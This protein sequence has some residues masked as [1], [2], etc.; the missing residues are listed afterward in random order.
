MAE[1]DKPMDNIREANYIKLDGR[2]FSITPIAN[3]EL[4][5]EA[6]LKQFYNEK[7]QS[8]IQIF[9]GG[10][11]SGM[12]DDWASQM[13]RLQ[14]YNS[15]SS[16]TVPAG[17]MGKYMICTNNRDIEEVRGVIYSPNIFKMVRGDIATN[18]NIEYHTEVEDEGTEDEVS[19]RSYDTT[20]SMPGTLPEIDLNDYQDDE[21]LIVEIRKKIFHCALYSFDSRADRLHCSN[22]TTFHNQ[23]TAI[24]TGSNKASDFW[25]S[26]NFNSLMNQ[27]N[28]F[29]LG[30][31]AV[32]YRYGNELN[33]RSHSIADYVKRSTIIKIERERSNSGWRT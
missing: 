8:H 32:Q 16:V 14:D 17:M 27:V 24:C 23:G 22:L 15:R 31:Q 4:N 20:I 21:V 2:V 30:S 13:T 33:R 7:Y 19:Y 11:V 25:N 12:T 5:L 1:D 29:S 3:S 28:C 18:L 26:D 9:N 6:E 10:Y